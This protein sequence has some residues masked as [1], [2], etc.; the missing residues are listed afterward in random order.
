VVDL[1]LSK[2]LKPVAGLIEPTPISAQP[3]YLLAGIANKTHIIN[4]NNNNNN[5]KPKTPIIIVGSGPSGLFA[6][7]QILHSPLSSTHYPLL[8]ERGF[9]VE[10]RGSSIGKF[11]NSGHLDP[12]SNFAFGE[13]GAG[14]WS[15]GKLTTRIGRNSV[16]VRSVLNA[17][18]AFGA[19]EKILT[20]GR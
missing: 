11:I 3:S 13:G 14:T 9:S 15:D 19:P 7:L 6:A 10:S 1:T 17:L 5:N 4:N 20:S 8:L 12:E 2:S 16:H 18:V